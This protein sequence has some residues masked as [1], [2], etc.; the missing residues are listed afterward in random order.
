MEVGDFVEDVT[1]PLTEPAN[2]LHMVS[3]EGTFWSTGNLAEAAPGVH[4]PLGW[5]IW[6]GLT[7]EVLWR[8]VADLGAWPR[9]REVSDPNTRF[10]CLFFGRYAANVNTFRELGN[11][12]PGTSGDA[13][14]E[15]F[16]G[17]K[18]SEERNRPVRSRYPVVIAKMPRNM[19]RAIRQVAS[20]RADN[21]RWWARRVFDSPP[22]GFGEGMEVLR[23]GVRRYRPVMREHMIVTLLAQG[24][25]EQLTKICRAAGIPGQ[26]GILVSGYGGMEETAVVADVHA[27]A[28]NRLSE[29]DFLRRHGYHGPNEGDVSSHPWREDPS[30]IRALAASYRKASADPLATADAT[31]AARRQAERDLRSRL[32]R[33]QRLAVP[34]VLAL[35]RRFVLGR[36]VGKAGFL[37]AMDGIRAGARALGEALADDGLLADPHDVFFL[38]LD[39]LLG[40]NRLDRRDEVAERR[41][42]YD[43]YRQLD[44]PGTWQGNPVPVPLS[45]STNPPLRQEVT[46]VSGIGV[47]PGTVTGVVRVVHEAASDQADDFEPGEILVCRITDPSWAPVLSIAAA[48]VIDIGGAMSHGAIVARELGIP[49]VI[50]TRDGTRQLRTGDRVTVDGASGTVRILS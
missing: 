18:M 23:E 10:G 50:N 17:A 24:S 8:V 35:T 5:G 14:E 13:V 47:S 42:R 25:F 1:P 46:E 20:H 7:E 29:W 15:Q 16:F 48:V 19:T 33:R 3:D 2:L 22:V 27:L 49:C 28:S 36:E 11:R 39:E 43:R 9:P 31:Q 37:L 30:P 44:L 41:E 4:T 40:D 21:F 26:E 34:P 38:T 12:L 6:G 45:H 32:S